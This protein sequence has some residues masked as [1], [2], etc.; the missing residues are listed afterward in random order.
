M[1]AS[2][3]MEVS[4]LCTLRDEPALSK[5][6]IQ[7][8]LDASFGRYWNFGTA[9]VWAAIDRLEDC[10]YI[11]KESSIPN[12]VTDNSM[13]SYSITADGVDRFES[14]VR[15]LTDDAFELSSRPEL[16]IK[17]H[18]LQHLDET[19]RAQILQQLREEALQRSDRI[20]T[21]MANADDDPGGDAA[22]YHLSLL[23]L[24]ARILDELVDWID[25]VQSHSIN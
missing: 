24:H 25:D 23:E 18:A 2:E 7:A 6:E 1:K 13:I 11:V 9:A 12:D 8:R 20:R 19:A 14:L 5:T 3:L 15:K 4:V 21:E 17:L 10:G 22:D 16:M